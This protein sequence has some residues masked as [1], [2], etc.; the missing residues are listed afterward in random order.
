GSSDLGK[1]RV[2]STFGSTV[3]DVLEDAGIKVGPHD[4][5][6]LAPNAEIGDN[7][8]IKL[9]RGRQLTVIE[10]GKQRQ[11]WVRATTVRDALVQLGKSNLVAQGDRKSTRLNSSH[12]KSSYAV[13][14][15]KKKSS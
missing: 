3:G 9:E 1:E 14:C 2:V 7:G 5:L 13:F 10:D 4:A 11:T 12:V 8:V 15:M 6:S